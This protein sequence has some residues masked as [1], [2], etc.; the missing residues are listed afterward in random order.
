MRNR[1]CSSLELAGR[2]N[3]LHEPQRSKHTD[4]PSYLE[5][6]V[7]FFG[8]EHYEPRYDYPLIV[9]LHSNASG[10]QEL[11]SVMPELSLRNYVA[12]APRGT[13]ACE[14][15]G[16]LYRWGESSS[17]AAIAEEV[18]FDSIQLA[19]SQFSIDRSR[20]FLMG[21]GG[22]GSM[23]WKVALRYP[24]RFAGVI[25]ICGEFPAN[26]RALSNYAAA[27]QLPT[28]WMYGGESTTCGIKQ[29]CESLPVMHA[30][31]LAV[32]IRQYPCRNELL[33]NMLVDANSWIME[34]VTQQ[35]ASSADDIVEES[36]SNN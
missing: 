2:I 32:D 7:C 30:A 5:N 1:L 10:E 18:L 31:S 16:D 3:K 21:F 12:C 28:M 24:N 17:S 15:E 34:R 4:E 36:F 20:V 35:P 29:V 6:Q 33:S 23:A 8:P 22:G 19:C 25:N 14:G 9:W 11:E 27:R 26:E 13:D